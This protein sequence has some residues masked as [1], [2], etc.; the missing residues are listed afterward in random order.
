MKK[1]RTISSNTSE[2]DEDEPVKEKPKV[3]KKERE[4]VEAQFRF[5]SGKDHTSKRVSNTDAV[6]HTPDPRCPQE[7]LIPT[8]F[9]GLDIIRKMPAYDI[10]IY[11]RKD[12]KLFA[13][14]TAEQWKVVTRLLLDPN[15][16]FLG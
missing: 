1:K 7:K 15:G 9:G 12:E 4:F 10:M 16:S 13:A 2:S 3:D 6:P 5:F 8:Q 14:N 11:I